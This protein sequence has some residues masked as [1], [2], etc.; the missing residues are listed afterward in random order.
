[1]YNYWEVKIYIYC[2]D[3]ILKMATTTSHVV[4]NPTSTRPPPWQLLVTLFNIGPYGNMNK[5]LFPHKPQTWL[6]QKQR[7]RNLVLQYKLRWTSSFN[8]IFF[9]TL[10]I[11]NEKRSF[12]AKNDAIKH[13][14]DDACIIIFVVIM[15]LAFTRVRTYV[16]PSI[17]YFASC[18]TLVPLK[19]IIWNL[20]T[21]S[22]TRQG[23]PRLI[24]DFTGVMLLDLSK[25]TCLLN[26]EMGVYVSYGHIFTFLT[27][28]F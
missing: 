15:A 14:I 7:I 28:F 25:I 22:E 13:Y 19:Q 24:P 8:F 18:L 1:M 17:S 5:K 21:R 26:L 12:K 4:V 16:R 9:Y 3:W 6:N 23:R 2:V 20:Y 10:I 27:C 11:S